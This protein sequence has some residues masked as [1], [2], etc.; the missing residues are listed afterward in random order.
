MV[1]VWVGQSVVCGLVAKSCLTLF[2]TPWAVTCQT[3]LSMEF[4]RQEYWSWLPFPSPGGVFPTQKSNPSLL[5]CRQ[6]LYHWAT[7]EAQ[8][9]VCLIVNCLLNFN[10]LYLFLLLSSLPLQVL[11][12][13][14]WMQQNHEQLPGVMLGSS[15]ETVYFWRVWLEYRNEPD[16]PPAHS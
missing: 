1:W 15:R 6:I 5:H 11:L 9:I 13:T 7:W 16:L 12:V 2:V 4:P 8:D 10:S 3:P 14:D